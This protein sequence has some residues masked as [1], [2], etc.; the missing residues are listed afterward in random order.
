MQERVFMNID[1]ILSGDDLADMVITIFDELLQQ[2]E[3]GS[4][5]HLLK[6]AARTF[7]YTQNFDAYMN[8]DGFIEFFATTSPE[9]LGNTLDALEDIG[10]GKMKAILQKAVAVWPSAIPEDRHEREDLLLSNIDAW[11][12]IFEDLSSQYLMYPEPMEVLQV[13]YVDKF[14]TD[15]E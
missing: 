1:E 6:P 12:K 10:A 15:F 13:N 9:H 3:N 5:L 4:Q 11:T 14:R 7:F 8:N 2:T